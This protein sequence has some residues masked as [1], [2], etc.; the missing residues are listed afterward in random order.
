MRLLFLSLKESRLTLP[1]IAILI[2]NWNGWEDTI[3]CLESI[4]QITYSNYDVIVID[5]GSYDESIQ[6]IKEY[7][8]GKVPIKSEFITFD[9]SNKPIQIFE[10]TEEDIET[11]DSNHFVQ[12]N[13]CSNKKIRIIRNKKNYGFAEGNNIGMRFALRFLNPDYVLLLNNDTVVDKN[14]LNELIN[15]MESSSV[16]GFA[17][18]KIYYYD[19]NNLINFAGGKVNFWKGK[20]YHIGINK[21][22]RGQYNNIKFVDYVNGACLLSKVELIK[23]IGLLDPK[24]FTYWEE[25]DWCIRGYR[26]NYRSLYIPKAIIWH[27]V[28][29][30]NI[31]KNNIYY[32]VRNMFWFMKKNANRYH[33]CSFILYFFFVRFWIFSGVLI[34]NKDFKGITIFIKAIRDGL[35]SKSKCYT[36]S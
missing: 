1:H 13:L 29:K 23:K 22:D 8:N 32:M 24:Y 14:F 28:A 35:F 20:A 21:I 11:H 4:Y 12:N 16:L 19:K 34:I 17:G 15:V 36:I 30:S 3:E 2:L 18:P 10:Y 31:N 5:N 25:T 26:N 7:C 33:Y 6:K 27:K 9:P